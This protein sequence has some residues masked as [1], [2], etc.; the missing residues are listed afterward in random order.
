MRS[1]REAGNYGEELA[2]QYL[3]K[4]GLTYM[5]SNWLCK[6]G[7]VDLVMQDGSTRVFIEVKLRSRTSY[8]EGLEMVTTQKQEK[9]IRAV[10]HYQQEKD[11]WGDVRFDVVA[12]SMDGDKPSI[13]HVEY[14]FEA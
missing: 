6:Y 14:A 12:I 10:K 8:A 11:Y 3:E 2:R 4:R 1:T 5:A 9:I 7:E 13:E